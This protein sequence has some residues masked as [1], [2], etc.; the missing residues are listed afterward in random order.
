MELSQQIVEIDVQYA[1]GVARRYVKLPHVEDD[2][3][4]AFHGLQRFLQEGLR[5]ISGTITGW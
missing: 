2:A 4:D 1:L 5:G 3:P